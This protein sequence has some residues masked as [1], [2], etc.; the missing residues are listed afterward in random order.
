VI[1]ALLGC[2]PLDPPPNQFDPWQDWDGDGYT[3]Y[4]DKDRRDCDDGDAAVHPGAD[5]ACDGVDQDCDGA[6]DEGLPVSTWWVDADGDGA[7]DDVLGPQ[8]GCGPPA[9]G[10]GAGGD[11]DDL[12]PYASVGQLERCWA[13]GD[14]DCDATA[15]S[16]RLAGDVSLDDDARP[17]PWLP[18]YEYSAAYPFMVGD[19]DGDGIVDIGLGYDGPGLQL[20]PSSG[21]ETVISVADPGV[22]RTLGVLARLASGPRMVVEAVRA[23]TSL[24]V[25]LWLVDPAAALPA[26]L[27]P[28]VADRHLFGD[29][30]VVPGFAMDAV[31]LDGGGADD[32]VL[33]APAYYQADSELWVLRGEDGLLGTPITTTIRGTP[34]QEG[35]GEGLAIVSDVGGTGELGLAL[36]GRSEAAVVLATDVLAGQW[37]PWTV[38]D[39]PTVGSGKYSDVTWGDLDGDGTADLVAATEGTVEVALSPEAGEAAIDATLTS[40]D[41]HNGDTCGFALEVVADLFGP[42]QAGLAVGCPGD[43]GDSGVVHLV[44]GPLVQG[45][46]DLDQ[47]WAHLRNAPALGDFGIGWWLTEP[48]TDLDGDGG[49]DLV[50]GTRR[51]GWVVSGGW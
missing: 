21:G 23:D 44:P 5:E 36:S 43:D 20:V 27:D 40:A 2:A 15:P 50:I 34:A 32:L 4:G 17:L 31:D 33:T 16:C 9:D 1:A 26:S 29:S 18:S 6:V 11:C 3:E 12:D 25:D 46:L 28:L 49:V 42:G 24:S 35:L 22:A 45:Q 48:G 14:E 38:I 19:L 8:S 39:T 13:P 37:S 51:D 10:V 41:P 7:G 30:F 47:A